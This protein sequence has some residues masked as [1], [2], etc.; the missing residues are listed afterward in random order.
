MYI[1]LLYISNHF[2]LLSTD[3]MLTGI[4]YNNG[5]YTILSATRLTDVLNGARFSP[6]SALDSIDVT[7][8][9][10]YSFIHYTHTLY[11]DTH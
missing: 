6:N 9:E 1:F 3:V 5:V 2:I 10:V 7:R 8:V 11:R 4:T